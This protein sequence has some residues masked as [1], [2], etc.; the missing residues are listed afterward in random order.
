MNVTI[1]TDLVKETV[2]LFDLLS[3]S[4]DYMYLN[5]ITLQPLTVEMFPTDDVWDMIPFHEFED[6]E[7]R[8]DLADDTKGGAIPDSDLGIEPKDLIWTISNSNGLTLR[9]Y[10]E[11]VFRMKRLKDPNTELLCGIDLTHIGRMLYM[12]VRFEKDDE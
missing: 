12:N 6:L 11:G 2:T 7:V 10:T 4:I 1:P 8:R 3:M 5:P 9:D